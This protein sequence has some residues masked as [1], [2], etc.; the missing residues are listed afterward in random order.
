MKRVLEVIS[1]TLDELLKSHL[2]ILILIPCTA[3]DY[4]V[5]RAAAAASAGGS[6]EEAAGNKVQSLKL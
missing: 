4:P 3:V 5:W 2:Y 6:E 1:H